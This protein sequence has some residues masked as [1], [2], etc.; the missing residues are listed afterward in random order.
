MYVTDNMRRYRFPTLLLL[1]LAFTACSRPGTSPAQ[2][3]PASE[4]A[5]QARL[6]TDGPGLFVVDRAALASLGWNAETPLAL[7]L[8]GEPYPVQA[9]EGNLYFYLPPTIESR[10]SKGQTLWLRPGTPL[11]PASGA[12]GAVESLVATRYESGNDFYNPKLIDDPWAWKQLFWTESQEIVVQTPGRLAG[13]LTIELS[14]A[15]STDTAHIVELSLGGEPVGSAEWQGTVR[16]EQSFAAEAAAGDSLTIT[17]AVPDNQGDVSLL[18]SLTLRYPSSP[19]GAEGLFT[20]RSEAGGRAT[21]EGIGAPLGWQLAP[22]LAPLAA[23]EG[24]ALALPAGADIVVTERSTARPAAVAAVGET[25]LPTEGADYVAIVAPELSA[26]LEPLLEMHRAQG[27][28][29]LTLTPQQIYDG[30]SHGQVEPLAMRAMLREARERW[31]VKPRFVLLVGDSTYDPAGY[32]TEPPTAYLPSPF[33]DTIFGGETVSDNL[34]ADLDDDGYPDVALG[35]LPART[36]E[37][38]TTHIEKIK[39]YTQSPADGAWRQRILLTADG[40]EPIFQHNSEMLRD[41]VPG[42]VAVETS[43]PEAG[44]DALAQMMPKLNEGSLIVNYVGHGSVQQWGRDQILTTQAVTDQLSN[45]DRLPIYINMTCLTGLFSHPSQESLAETLLWLPSGG[46]I[47]AVAPSSLTLPNDQTALNNA[48]VAQLLSEERPTI[49][50]ALNTAKRAVSLANPTAHD[51]VAT[52][53]LLG[54]PALR[55][56][57]QR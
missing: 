24:G 35:R 18:D 26:A 44:S 55:P 5:A 47:A 54:D 4:P 41:S 34:I 46:S 50:E 48:L 56:V 17:I 42:T 2:P 12:E 53:N 14:L 11:A 31:S 32:Q 6:T 57:P 27:L 43:Y 52:F 28:T 7:T 39:R 21:F 16:H 33:I 25:A 51:I 8:D 13:E 49:G 3:T 36:P 45:G 30:Y 37:Q 22:A 19:K 15:G 29:T 1:L 20:G 9:R 38:L 40:Q 23:D 10:Y